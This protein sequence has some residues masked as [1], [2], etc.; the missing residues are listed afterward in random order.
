MGVQRKEDVEGPN[1]WETKQQQ[2]KMGLENYWRVN[3]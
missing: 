2:E 1:K 3:T